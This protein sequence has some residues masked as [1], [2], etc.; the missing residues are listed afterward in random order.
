MEPV[1]YGHH[2]SSLASLSSSD[3]IFCVP[4]LRSNMASSSS[5]SSKQ[6]P[7]S[8]TPGYL[9]R[10]GACFS[11]RRRKMRCDGNHPVCGQCER[12]GRLEDCEYTSGHEKS[13][14]QILEENITRLE[15]RIRELQNPELNNAPVTL[16]QPYAVQDPPRNIAE[17]LVKG[18]LVHASELGFFLNKKKFYES[19]MLSQPVGNSARPSPALIYTVYLWGI[20]LSDDPA[21]KKYEPAYLHRA[22]QDAATALSGSHPHRIMHS[23]QAEVLLSAYFFAC[24][25]FFEGKYHVA[26]AVSTLFSAGLHKIRAVSAMAP[27]LSSSGRLEPPRDSMDEAQ[28]IL[29]CWTA[30]I[31]DKSWAI[32][33]DHSPNF[34]YSTHPVSAKIDTPWPL[35]LEDGTSIPPQV[36]T[37]DTIQNFLESRLSNDHGVST[38]AI[39]AKA[40]ILWERALL[41]AR[42]ISGSRSHSPLISD[43][44]SS[45]QEGTSPTQSS[46]DPSQV[47]LQPLM[48][49]FGAYTALIDSVFTQLPPGNA[50]TILSSARSSERGRRL[51]V[52][53]TLLHLAV[54][55][56][57]GPFAYAG[58]SDTSRHQR[59][60]S[61]RQIMEMAIALRAMNAGYL[62]PIIGTAWV[63]AA[64][65]C[66]DEIARIRSLRAGG[67]QT[68]DDVA[69]LALVRQAIG[70]MAGFGSN[71]PLISFQ[72]SKIQETF[73]S[74]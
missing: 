37:S 18:F 38:W 44:S 68:N 61:A 45:N 55:V 30:L 62:N 47:D 36:R 20:R 27:S 32:A 66:Y 13:T 69:L 4:H 26:T 64:Q 40:S 72:V 1:Y 6:P 42:K 52:A 41:F 25:R 5:S 46:L 43:T 29:C 19:M 63:E 39:Q 51:G 16:H 14:V 50:Q 67:L 58:R 48:H 59:V 21:V 71:M 60:A 73:Q 22:T 54:V 7:R 9:P 49:E 11:C 31:L 24:G 33:L 2:Y 10:G 56:L 8:S 65:V 70:A 74:V 3:T 28:R 15:A 12:A 34:E 57:H 35:E 17:P 23:L 53:Y